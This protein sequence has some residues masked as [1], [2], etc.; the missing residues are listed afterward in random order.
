[1]GN[2]LIANHDNDM[3]GLVMQAQKE[4]DEIIQGTLMSASRPQQGNVLI[5]NKKIFFIAFNE[6]SMH[7]LY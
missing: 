3:I 1:M 4:H 6:K 5:A 7:Y 2:V